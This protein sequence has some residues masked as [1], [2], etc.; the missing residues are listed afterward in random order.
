ME[1]TVAAHETLKARVHRIIFGH[2]TPAGKMF[3]VILIWLILA[4][5][6]VV[7]L[8]SVP[9]V[10]AQYLG[11]LRA[12]EWGFTILFTIEYA[13]RLWCSPSAGRYARSFFGV[14]D[15]LAVI[16]TYLTL[17]V[18]GGQA[19]VTVRAIR[20]LRVFRVLKLAHYVSE[21][22]VLTRALRASRHKIIVFVAGVL[23]LVV[24]LGSLMY[25]VEGAKNGFTS[26][27]KSVYWA[28]VTLTTVGY[29]DIAPQ[30]D[31]GQAL[32]AMVMI[33]GYAIIAVPTGIVTVEIGE[34]HRR[35]AAEDACKRC[36]G[37]GHQRDARFC[38]LCAQ[39]LGTASLKRERAAS[40]APE[41]SSE[42]DGAR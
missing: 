32:A 12:A 33:L 17:F 37:T 34:A 22:T 8:E 3:D 15:L 19:L 26:I 18:P 9:R 35:A 38:R 2:D 14:I 6:L 1:S 4:S 41:T 20:L 42:G 11:V 5:V 10:R 36:G 24:I 29:G 27:P 39:P 30:T 13:A 25:L 23:I 28:I 40:A 7:M 31:I 16:P 21:A